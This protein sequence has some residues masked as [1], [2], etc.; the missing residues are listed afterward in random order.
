MGRNL[1][2]TTESC[3]VPMGM[4]LFYRLGFVD[5]NIPESCVKW[6]GTKQKGRKL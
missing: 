6:I 5:K 1:G 2:G 4:E 3:F